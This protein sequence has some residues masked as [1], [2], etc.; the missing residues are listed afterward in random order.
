MCSNL[1]QEIAECLDGR[2][3]DPLFNGFNFKKPE[4]STKSIQ[5][6]RIQCQM[7]AQTTNDSVLAERLQRLVQK[8]VG[9]IPKAELHI[10]FGALRI[11]A[12]NGAFQF[13]PLG[14]FLLFDDI[15]RNSALFGLVA[16]AATLKCLVNNES[17]FVS[18]KS[19]KKAMNMDGPSIRTF[20]DF[21]RYSHY[22]KVGTDAQ[23]CCL[24]NHNNFVSFALQVWSESVSNEE[25][26]GIHNVIKFFLCGYHD[27]GIPH[28]LPARESKPKSSATRDILFRPRSNGDSETAPTCHGCQQAIVSQQ[29]KGTCRNCGKIC[30]VGCIDIK[31][32]EEEP[33]ENEDS[34]VFCMFS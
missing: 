23:S 28:R 5:E 26:A 29:T 18:L 21:M 2:H 8:L 30:H 7:F 22:E 3:Q 10:L 25:A 24:F 14:N 19:F 27:Y 15:C 13:N 17:A 1:W 34:G 20:T 6:F 4:E 11:S 32:C 33:N 12:A 31:P 16:K 9:S